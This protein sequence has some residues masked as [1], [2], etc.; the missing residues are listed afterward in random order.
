MSSRVGGVVDPAVRVGVDAVVLRLSVMDHVLM[1]MRWVLGLA[2]AVVVLW[3]G[4]AFLATP[5]SAA[6]VAPMTVQS[7]PL[8]GGDSSKGGGGG[9]DSGGDGDSGEKSDDDSGKHDEKSDGSDGEK[10]EK[11]SDGEHDRSDEKSDD[12]ENDSEKHS[13]SDRQKSSDSTDSGDREESRTRSA[14]SEERSPERDGGDRGSKKDDEPQESGSELH[15]AKGKAASKGDRDDADASDEPRADD[16]NGPAE[17]AVDEVR[18]K[19]EEK[20]RPEKRSADDRTADGDGAGDDAEAGERDARGAAQD[21]APSRAE[22]QSARADRDDSEGD[23]DTEVRRWATDV[24]DAVAR[25]RDGAAEHADRH[26]D[27]HRPAGR[28]GDVVRQTAGEDGR[29]D[30]GAEDMDRR[31]DV[32]RLV[33]RVGEVVQRVADGEDEHQAGEAVDALVRDAGRVAGASADD[34]HRIQGAVREA[35]ADHLAGTAAER[36]QHCAEDGCS[37]PSADEVSTLSSRESSTTRMRAPPHEHRDDDEH[38]DDEHRDDEHWGDDSAEQ[39]EK[40]LDGRIKVDRSARDLE[41]AGKDVAAGRKTKA[42]Y[43]EQAAAHEELEKQYEADRAELSDDRAE[44]VDEVVDGHEELDAS[45]KRLAAEEQQVAAGKVSA[46]AHDENVQAH[47]EQRAKVFG[48]TDELMAATGRHVSTVS[49]DDLDGPG[50]AAG[51][52]S[53]GAFTACGSATRSADGEQDT[54]RRVCLA[55]ISSGC[56]ASSTSGDSRAAASC[57]ATG[58]GSSASTRGADGAVSKASARCDGSGCDQSSRADRRGASAEC[59]SG[60]GG[61]RTD[62]TVPREDRAGSS[63]ASCAGPDGCGVRSR[64]DLGDDDVVATAAVDCTAN[65]TGSANGSTDAGQKATDGKADCTVAGGR[66]ETSSRSDANGWDRGSA[67]SSHA[68]VD[69][70]CGAGCT[71]SGTTATAGN[72]RGVAAGAERTGSG[73]ASCAATGSHCQAHAGTEVRSAIDVRGTVLTDGDARVSSEAGADADCGTAACSGKASSATTGARAAELATSPAR[74]TTASATCEATAGG[75]GVGSDSQVTD[76]A[77]RVSASSDAGSWTGCAAATCAASGTSGTTGGASGDVPGVR[78]SS[79]SSTCSARGAGGSCRTT[80]DTAVADRGRTGPVS[81]S[82]AGGTVD[83]A[84]AATECGA[85]ATSSTSAR[86]TAVSAEARGTAATTECTVTGGGCAGDTASAASS[87]PDFVDAVTGRPATGPSSTSTS[88]AALA[89]EQGSTCSGSVRTTTSAWDGAVDGGRPRTSEGTASCTG[90][91]GGCQVQSVSTAST[92]PGAAQALSGQEAVNAARMTGGPSAASAAGAALLCEGQQR[93]TGT[94]TSAAGAT[95]PAVSAELRGSRSEGSCEGVAGGVCQAVTNSGAS[96][97]PNA[98]IIRPLVQARSTDNATVSTRTTGDAPADSQHEDLPAAPGSSAN[99]GGPTVPGASSWSMASATMDCAG[100]AVCTGTARTSASGDAGITSLNGAGGVRGPP[101]AG[102]STTSGS[103]RTSQ[104][105]CHVQTDSAAGSGQVVADMVAEQQNDQAEQA[106]QQAKKAEQ[107]AAEAARIAARPGATAAQKQTAADAAAAAKDARTTATEAAALAAKPVTDAPD[108]LTQSSATARCTGTRCT[109]ATTGGTAGG[110]TA[111]A[112]CTAATSGCGVGSE[113]TTTTGSGRATAEVECP[114]IGCTGSVTGS[115]SATAGGAVSTATGDARCD[116]TTVCQAQISV[117]TTVATSAPGAAPDERFATTSASVS[118]AC[119]NGTASGCATHAASTSNAVGADQVRATGTATCAATGR[120]SAATG[121]SA[122]QGFAEVSASC[123]GTACTT[124]TE[125]NATAASPHGTNTATARSDCTAGTGGECAGSSRV[126]ASAEYALA[127]AACATTGGTCAFEFRAESRANG[128]GVH[129]EGVAGGTGT[130]GSGEA[131]TSALVDPANGVAQASASCTGTGVACA[132][133]YRAESH[134]R[135]RGAKADAVGFGL[136]G[137]GGGYVATSASAESRN[138]FAQASASCQGSAGT[139][140]SHHWSVSVSAYASSPTGSWASARASD[141]GGGAMGASGGWVFASATVDRYG[142]P[143]TSVACSNEAH[144]SKHYA[145]HIEFAISW[146]QQQTWDD[147]GGIWNARRFGDCSGSS[148]NGCGLYRN[149]NDVGCTG[150]CSNFR[151]SMST[152]VFT[153]LVP[154]GKEVWAAQQRARAPTAADVA[155][156]GPEETGSF[157]GIDEHGNRVMIVKDR[158]QAARTCDA[159]CIDA[160]PA[161]SDGRRTFGDQG[162]A[163]ATWTPNAGDPRSTYGASVTV[164]PSDTRRHEVTGER[165]ARVSEDAAGNVQVWTGGRGRVTDGRTGANVEVTPTNPQGVTT[166]RIVDR[167]RAPFDGEV[168]GGVAYHGPKVDL[169]PA[170]TNAPGF[171]QLTSNAA[172]VK[173]GATTAGQATFQVAGTGRSTF[174]SAEGVVVHANGDG[175]NFEDGPG[176]NVSLITPGY[177][178]DGRVLAPGVYAVTGQTGDITFPNGRA[179]TN[180]NDRLFTHDGSLE[181][182]RVSAVT[183]LEPGRGGSFGCV[184]FCTETVPGNRDVSLQNCKDICSVQHPG[185]VVDPTQ[186]ACTAMCEMRDEFGGDWTSKN[187]AGYFQVTMLGD[188]N[189][190]SFTPQGDAAYC[191]GVGCHYTQGYRDQN[192]NYGFMTCHLGGSGGACLGE[193]MGSNGQVTK[194]ECRGMADC[195]PVVLL[196]PNR[197]DPEKYG[198]NEGWSCG[199]GVGVS[200]CVSN[201]DDL[202]TEGRGEVTPGWMSLIDPDYRREYRGTEADRMLAR[203]LAPLGYKEGDPLPPLDAAA[204]ANLTPDQRRLYDAALRPLSDTEKDFASA[205]A[206]N[207]DADDRYDTQTYL[208]TLPQVE[209]ATARVD[210]ALR[211]G[212]FSPSRYA[213]DLELIQDANAR[214]ERMSLNRGIAGA[215]ATMQYQRPFVD[216]R[217]RSAAE[218]PTLPGDLQVRSLVEG[219]VELQRALGVNRKGQPLDAQ[220]NVI[221]SSPQEKA[222]AI[223]DH[224]PYVELTPTQKA[225]SDASRVAGYSLIGHQEDVRRRS[226]A[227]EMQVDWLLGHGATQSDVARV[228]ALENG[229]N[230]DSAAIGRVKL[231]LGTFVKN[232]NLPGVAPDTARL[233]A[234]DIAIAKN[235]GE[236]VMAADLERLNGFQTTLDGI[237]GRLSNSNDPQ[238]KALAEVFGRLAVV[239]GLSYDT[240]AQDFGFR[241]ADGLLVWRENPDR[242]SRHL[243]SMPSSGRPDMVYVFNSA[244]NSPGYYSYADD[245]VRDF[246]QH[247]DR[248]EIANWASAFTAA[249]QEAQLSMIRAVDPETMEEMLTQLNGGDREKAQKAL[250]AIRSIGGENAGAADAGKAGEVGIVQLYINDPNKPGDGY[251]VETVL[252]R[253]RGADGQT[254]L[255]DAEG[256]IFDNWHDYQQYNSLAEDHRVLIAADLDAPI[257]ESG[258]LQDV[259]GHDEPTWKTVGKWV[260]RGAMVVGGVAL[261]VSGVGAPLGAASLAA[262][263]STIATVSFVTSAVAMGATAGGELIARGQHNQSTSWSD[264]TARS[265]WITAGASL[266]VVGG[267]LVAKIGALKAVGALQATGRAAGAVGGVVMGGQMAYSTYTA[268]RDWDT[269][270]PAQRTEFWID[271]GIGALGL[272]G[273]G[274]KLAGSKIATFRQG[275]LQGDVP[276][277]NQRITDLTA[278]RGGIRPSVGELATELGI[279]KGTVRFALQEAQLGPLLSR[280]G[281]L[282]VRAGG[283]PTVTEVVRETGVTRAEARAALRVVEAARTPE[284]VMAEKAMGRRGEVT[285]EEFRRGLGLFTSTKTKA[286]IVD[287]IKDGELPGFTFRDGTIAYAPTR[288]AP[289]PAAPVRPAPTPTPAAQPQGYVLHEP[290]AGPVPNG[291]RVAAA[292]GGRNVITV[293]EFLAGLGDDLTP[294]QKAVV[295]EQVK[296]GNLDGFAYDEVGALVGHDPHA[297]PTGKGAEPDGPTQ[298]ATG[299]DARPGGPAPGDPPPADPVVPGGP[300]DEALPVTPTGELAGGKRQNGSHAGPEEDQGDGGHDRPAGTIGEPGPGNPGVPGTMDGNHLGGVPPPAPRNT[301]REQSGLRDAIE[302]RRQARAQYKAA[303][304]QVREYV[305][306]FRKQS[307]DELVARSEEVAQQVENG[308]RAFADGV[309]EC[310]AIACEVARRVD[311]DKAPRKGQV[312]GAVALARDGHVIEMLTGEGKT[313]TGAV[314]VVARSLLEGRAGGQVQWLSPNEAYAWDAFKQVRRIAKPLGRSVELDTAQRSSEGKAAVDAARIKVG[315]LSEEAFDVLRDGTRQAPVWRLLDEVDQ[316]LLDDVAPFV[317]SEQIEGARP[318]LADLTWAKRIADADVLAPATRDNPG[319]H[320]DPRTY[321]LTEAGRGWLDTQLDALGL[322]DAAKAVLRQRVENALRARH[323]LQRDVDYLVE[324]GEIVLLAEDNRPLYGR[325]LSEGH[326]AVELKEFGRTGV[327]PPSRTI[328]ALTVADLLAQ[329]EWAGMTGT[330]GGKAGRGQF[331]ANYGKQ[332]VHIEPHRRSRRVDH[333]PVNHATAAAARRA[334]LTDAL[335]A[336]AHGFPVLIRVGSVAEALVMEGLLWERGVAAQMITAKAM[337]VA[338]ESEVI[339]HAGRRGAVTIATDMAGRARDIQLGGAVDALVTEYLQRHHPDLASGVAGYAEARARATE[340]AAAHIAAELRILD[341]EGGGLHVIGV[342]TARNARIEDQLR[343][344]SGRNGQHGVTRVHRSWED[345]VVTEHA[346]VEFVAERGPVEVTGRLDSAAADTVFDLVRHDAE[347]AANAR[348]AAARHGAA[349]GTDSV[350]AVLSGAQLAEL[351]ALPANPAGVDLHQ[352]AALRA[353]EPVPGLTAEQYLQ[354]R[355]DAQRFAVEHHPTSQE[356]VLAAD[357]LAALIPARALRARPMTPADVVAFRQLAQQATTA[358]A[359]QTD[360]ADRLGMSGSELVVTVAEAQRD[361]DVDEQAA[362]V[363]HLN[364]LSVEAR[365]LASATGKLAAGPREL[366]PDADLDAVQRRAELATA[367]EWGERELADALALAA[368]L[369]PGQVSGDLVEELRGL[370]GLDRLAILR[371]DAAGV[372]HPSVRHPGVLVAQAGVGLVTAPAV[373][374]YSRMLALLA[375]DDLVPAQVRDRGDPERTRNWAARARDLAGWWRAGVQRR[376][377]LRELRSTLAGLDES[378]GDGLAE[379]AEARAELAARDAELADWQRGAVGRLYGAPDAWTADPAVDA[380]RVAQV[381]RLLGLDPA[382]VRSYTSDA[383]E[384]AGSFAEAL[385]QVVVA[386]DVR[387]SAV[388]DAAD[389][390]DAANR[391]LAELQAQRPGALEDAV[392]AAAAAGVPVPRIAALTGLS[393]EEVR[394]IVDPGSGAGG[395]NPSGVEPERS[396]SP[397]AGSGGATG[398]RA[399]QPHAGDPETRTRGPPQPTRT[400]FTRTAGAVVLFV[401]GLV[402]A[403]AAARYGVAE[404]GALAAGV[405]WWPGRRAAVRTLRTDVADARRRLADAEDAHRRAGETAR[406]AELELQAR[407]GWVPA[408]ADR[409][410]QAGRTDDRIVD[411]LAAALALH[412]ARVRARLSDPDLAGAAPLPAPLVAPGLSATALLAVARAE[413]TVRSADLGDALTRRART[414]EALD[415]A[416]IR[417]Q[418]DLAWVAREARAAGVRSGTVRRAT[419]LTRTD[420]ATLPAPTVGDVSHAVGTRI[421]V[422]WETAVDRL[423]AAG[424]RVAL[425]WETAVDTVRAAGLRAGERWRAV[426]ARALRGV[427]ALGRGWRRTVERARAGRELRAQVRGV[428]R[429]RATVGATARMLRGEQREAARSVTAEQLAWIGW[430]AALDGTRLTT[431]LIAREL[432]LS[433]PVARGLLARAFRQGVATPLA[434]GVGFDLALALVKARFAEA[435]PTL[436]DAARAHA[437]AGRALDAGQAAAMQRATAAGVPSVRAGRR[438]D[439]AGRGR[440]WAGL[441]TR[442]WTRLGMD[443]PVAERLRTRHARTAGYLTGAGVA[444]G[445]LGIVGGGAVTGTVGAVV[446]ATGLV[447]A[448]RAVWTPKQARGPPWRSQAR[449]LAGWA[450]GGV[451]SVLGAEP[452]ARA[453]DALFPVLTGQPGLLGVKALLVP[454]VTAGLVFRYVLRRQY[455]NQASGMQTRPWFAAWASAATAYLLTAA[456]GLVKAFHLVTGPWWLVPVAM[457]VGVGITNAILQKKDTGRTRIIKSLVSGT[458]SAAVTFVVGLLGSGLAPGAWGDLLSA[459]ATA[460]FVYASPTVIAEYVNVW[461]GR[462]MAPYAKR[463]ALQAQK[464]AAEGSGGSERQ[465]RWYIAWLDYKNFSPVDTRLLWRKALDPVLAGLSAI[466]INLAWV[467]KAWVL[468]NDTSLVSV[469]ARFAVA[470]AAVSLIG[471]LWRDPDEIRHGYYGFRS[472]RKLRSPGRAPRWTFVTGGRLPYRAAGYRRD[473]DR[474][475]DAFALSGRSLDRGLAEELAAQLWTR[476]VAEIH[477]PL[478]E[479]EPLP[480]VAEIA[481]ALARDRAAAKQRRDGH[482]DTVVLVVPVLAADPGGLERAADQLRRAGRPT[483]AAAV[484]FQRMLGQALWALFAERWREQAQRAEDAQAAREG[485]TPRAIAAP[486]PSNRTWAKQLAA[487]VKKRNELREQYLEGPRRELLEL[488]KQHYLDNG[489]DDPNLRRARAALRALEFQLKGMSKPR[490]DPLEAVAQLADQRVRS[491]RDTAETEELAI[492]AR[493][494]AASPARLA[495]MRRLEA[496]MRL[497]RS[498]A[499]LAVEAE[500]SRAQRSWNRGRWRTA[501]ATATGTAPNPAPATLLER[502][503]LIAGRRAPVTAAEL[504]AQYGGGSWAT[505]LPELAAMQALAGDETNGYRAA[506]EL[507]R[508]WRAAGPRLRHAV[509]SAAAAL[510]GGTDLAPLAVVE[511]GSDGVTAAERDALAALYDLLRDGDLAFRHWQDGWFDDAGVTWRRVLSLGYRA[512]HSAG[513]FDWPRPADHPAAPIRFARTVRADAVTW[514]RRG[515]VPG[516]QRRLLRRQL[517]RTD[518]ADRLYVRALRAEAVLADRRRAAADLLHAAR[519]AEVEAYAQLAEARERA[520]AALRAAGSYLHQ[521]DRTLRLADDARP[522]A[523]DSDPLPP[524]AEHWLHEITKELDAATA[525]L[526]RLHAGPERDAAVAEA[527]LLLKRHDIDRAYAWS[528][529]LYRTIGGWK[530]MERARFAAKRLRAAHEDVVRKQAAARPGEHGHAVVP[531]RDWVAHPYGD[532]ENTGPGMAAATRRGLGNRTNQDAAALVPLANG[533]RVALVVDGV[534]SYPGSELAAID[535]AT[536]FRAELNRVD[537]PGRSPPDALRDAHQAG[538]DALA[539]RRTPET[540]HAGVAYLAAHHG[541]DGRITIIWAGSA[542]AYV[543]PSD[544]AATGDLLTVDDTRGGDITDGGIMTRWAA[545]DYRPEP[546]VLQVPAGVPG[547]LVLVTDG[548]WRYLPTAG[549]IAGVLG[550]A[551][552]AMVTDPGEAAARLAAAAR[553][554]GGRDDLTVAVL[555][556]PARASRGSADG[557]MWIP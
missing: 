145:A 9:D 289:T 528:T 407:L 345:R 256:G 342:G 6:T 172:W 241:S 442:L 71:G 257:G 522:H 265:L 471:K 313:L 55:G 79:G 307:Y 46:A 347:T 12:G 503:L 32:R 324:N 488:I 298:P 323:G 187:P 237:V 135:A 334:A 156:M 90:G 225:Q 539:M 103:C 118:V 181:S 396:P 208:R 457:A 154:S 202:R 454:L 363:G 270:T 214:A 98:N 432:G 518:A 173:L 467:D 422:T 294:L 275:A 170:V 277:I 164:G 213:D 163:Q 288:V 533:D 507:V 418:Q 439:R 286:E 77:R 403:L 317:L 184:G 82:H 45:E 497:V 479:W 449:R 419:G 119:D 78:D 221:V 117:G 502:L 89:C 547:L 102:T 33:E 376:A 356:Q 516:Q 478:P 336:H 437:A 383:V 191:G 386:Q 134:A 387:E 129:A 281:D 395:S 413:R 261:I 303:W 506:D 408:L 182:F 183:E 274:V 391:R 349:D 552:R 84:G 249:E 548:L 142:N 510:P 337:H 473:L 167:P 258:R 445:L 375:L 514:W 283:R 398:G 389:R 415:E 366:Q 426:E 305:R 13:D 350:A 158:G 61:C 330:A 472:K 95:D 276:G 435:H 492:G 19:V 122:A 121:A 551:G 296:Q 444:L 352:L 304:Q 105:G 455:A 176:N 532:D 290:V 374:A 185:E 47:E 378:L 180:H 490:S 111:T 487:A 188:G 206:V 477:E 193:T 406:R 18:E 460:T 266:I 64:V 287:L 81:V 501:M 39:T 222:Q 335:D 16:R 523:P 353:A 361:L 219:N 453:V 248:N 152:P 159:A 373:N 20:T 556:L 541:A 131:L 367:P 427:A 285:V 26:E 282:T 512:R 253:V 448:V 93:C 379:L 320:Y 297:S 7:S 332:V 104:S 486:A 198:L 262:A 372:P 300:G 239:N 280:I 72:A 526:D 465:R 149:G 23:V 67:G 295:L 537:R 348:L 203:I 62:S 321:R 299:G 63:L 322:G 414:A 452:L 179:I 68:A 515:A 268:I 441:R 231:D 355:A 553:A 148:G 116:G 466:V 49:T 381:A 424:R 126:A 384:S 147:P 481:D 359:N 339:A 94:V 269:L 328:A 420:V 450:L 210:Q 1:I 91:T 153:Q 87:A 243:L 30:G 199:S 458:L 162:G 462:F 405:F 124:H 425:V 357:R 385:A 140:C 50:A 519:A 344:R 137:I 433:V 482:P 245:K 177:G 525:R 301:V 132:F 205:R 557:E 108:S 555:H 190:T 100:D 529:D 341:V 17:R 440:G 380:V 535:F 429:L 40:V 143:S 536:A 127:G 138:G 369:A 160:L 451:G 254:K 229:I 75:C 443:V 370:L 260:G 504:E 399:A 327:K 130:T 24:V 123:A 434:D 315:A 150:D 51:C 495:E 110:S 168:F 470:A 43:A 428:A 464:N 65:C 319:G 76:D 38:R 139:D 263:A 174:T 527:R 54:E 114:E 259:A 312:M 10:H 195:N 246:Y 401:A 144:C 106:E 25:G 209:A 394:A 524:T 57:D 480:S 247:R 517:R 227:L 28:S 364:G 520:A 513:R 86:D 354:A 228:E 48:A 14:D 491:V 88:H 416:R 365:A 226:L 358:F 291:S 204:Y 468:A 211:N 293:E 264:P 3:I 511:L 223:A 224:V 136:G 216:E 484:D 220:G 371:G 146:T 29:G 11:D 35:V 96:S 544:P 42:D 60:G 112:T 421:G 161:G 318:A 15:S 58:C 186:R 545:S 238:E 252:F 52:G 207:A 271:T 278:L 230:A 423:R 463:K 166:L 272:L 292:M 165:S 232:A 412:P 141:S 169:P 99:S 489:L 56:G 430:L 218:S 329:G 120:C 306:G 402:A 447:A 546:S 311:P 469:L 431:D 157:S 215:L 155:A 360:L 446:A 438:I 496:G 196:Y 242:D 250:D 476:M 175:A 178:P 436:A 508:L 409:L 59:A 4:A 22:E 316:L 27:E 461:V 107:L 171:D 325:R 284:A 340:W 475:L 549:A 351:P 92:G 388:R 74:T 331:S 70:D 368:G 151:Q 200:G 53:D 279:S 251:P 5:A 538:L 393:A 333:A 308:E 494:P 85:T 302:Q 244:I 534:F 37:T 21:R 459:V 240:V 69:V 509:R 346:P 404:P 201:R 194:L 314:A 542:R 273:G 521:V 83:C 500:H 326:D 217:A 41:Q 343:G 498:A 362:L 36:Q 133:S 554:A 101:A 212:T 31:S 530:V 499:R 550:P 235:A 73:T 44:L 531:H 377:A 392:R 80:A 97:E 113:A 493:D 382:E 474:V 543:V 540:G 485:R 66:C 115:A 8:K 483:D 255:V 505:A 390:V 267:G 310:V 128:P 411:D 2:G 189:V 192:G 125:G 234:F 34:V 410:R 309:V 400:I 236:P 197:T 456:F 397:R 109:A 417:T 233:R 338:R